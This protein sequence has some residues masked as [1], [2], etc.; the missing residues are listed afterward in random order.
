MNETLSKIK[1]WAAPAFF[2]ISGLLYIIFIVQPEL[3]FHNE[4]PGFIFSTVYYNQFLNYPGGLAELAANLIVQSFYFKFAGPVVLFSITSLIGWSTC[5]LI[6]SV[7]KSSL[8][9]IWSLLPALLTIVLT[10]NY[11]FPFSV[12]VSI[13]FL[14]LILLVLSKT[15]KGI[16]TGILFYTFGSL[17]AYW[18]AGSGYF[19][20]FSLTAIFISS[21]LKRWLKAAYIMFIITFA[22]L[23]PLMA[24]NYLFAVS[25]KFQYFWFFA[26][27]AW[28]MK[29]N[30]TSIFI[31]YIILIPVLIIISKVISAFEKDKSEEKTKSGLT[32]LKTSLALIIVLTVAFFSHFLTFNSD[33]KKIVEADYYCYLGNPEKTAKA[34]TTLREYNFGANLNYNLVF[35]KTGD[36]TDNFFN[37][38]QIKG[39]ESLHPDV[40]FASEFSFIASDYYYD[41]GLISEAKHWANESLVFYPYSVRAMQNLVKIHLVTGEYKAAEKTLKTLNKG[42]I[43]KKFVDQYMPYIND[44]SL[45]KTN[46]ELMEKRSYIP[47]EKELNPTIDGRYRELLDANNDNKK[48]FEHLMLFYM[49]DARLDKFFDLY[50]NVSRYFDKTPDIYEEA[51]LMYSE[52]T[53]SDLPPEIVISTETKNRFNGFIKELNQYKG[54]TRMARNN[55]YAEY[56]KTYFYFLKFVYPSIMEPDI[57]TDEDD[58]PEI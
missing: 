20:I 49:L 48:A 31:L 51:L 19:M 14:L 34:S 1:H 52:R 41:L 27:M 11:N 25:L 9:R 13:T 17:A 6:N 33:A 42:L 30:P 28:F 46:H 45:V 35:S 5:K 2:L 54:K 18:T 47:A 32:I 16:F 57:I 4:Q 44:T 29:Y 36:L 24:S 15:T 8:N 23:F 43:D 7:N 55:L 37:F 26:P 10:N 21:P 56:G 50:K 38:M 39:T 58:Y 3:I 53:G 12:I 40:E 22:L